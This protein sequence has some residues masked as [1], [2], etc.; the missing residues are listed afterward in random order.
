M[1]IFKVKRFF[2]KEWQEN[3][4]GLVYALNISFLSWEDSS[5]ATWLQVNKQRCKLYRLHKQ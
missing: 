4:E 5:E 1:T 3:E 2:Q